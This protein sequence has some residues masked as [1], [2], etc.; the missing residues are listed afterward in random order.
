MPGPAAGHHARP[1]PHPARGAGVRLPAARRGPA[2]PRALLGP[3]AAR[4]AQPHVSGGLRR[5]RSRQAG[6]RP[7]L[8]VHPHRP[9]GRRDTGGDARPPPPPQPPPPPPPPRPPPPSPP[10]AL[11]RPPP[12]PPPPHPP[13]H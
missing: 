5:G 1:G 6:P 7:G 10:R 9:D 3:Q 12:P 4:R 13:P 2:R 11:P 8:P